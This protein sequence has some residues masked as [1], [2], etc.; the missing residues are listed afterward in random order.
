M[1]AAGVMVPAAAAALAAEPPGRDRGMMAT[2]RTYL[3]KACDSCGQ[4]YVPTSGRQRYCPDCALRHSHPVPRQRDS[5]SLWVRMQESFT[6]RRCGAE[7]GCRCVTST[8]NQATQPH[9]ERYDDAG[10]A[11]STDETERIRANARTRASK[12]AVRAANK[13]RVL[14]HYGTSCACCGATEPLTIDHISGDG[15]RHREEMGSEA[16]GVLHAWLIKS[17]FPPGFQTLCVS[18]NNSK[19]NGD[20]CRLIHDVCPACHR[21][22]ESGTSVGSRRRSRGRALA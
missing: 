16:S 14:A 2:R 13:Q 11:D 7:P 3:A 18:C 12:T 1:S 4:R 9:R 17:N 10:L 8:G 6:C 22:L 20:H 21:P 5:R 15:K 19:K